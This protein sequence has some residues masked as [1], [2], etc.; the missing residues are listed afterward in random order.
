[1]S[2]RKGRSVVVSLTSRLTALGGILIREHLSRLGGEKRGKSAPSSPP[3]SPS[4]GRFCTPTMLPSCSPGILSEQS[5]EDTDIGRD[6]ARHHVTS[7]KWPPC[8]HCDMVPLYHCP[9]TLIVYS[10]DPF[11][12]PRGSLLNLSSSTSYLYAI[13]TLIYSRY[14]RALRVLLL[15]CPPSKNL[16]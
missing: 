14:L 15:A 1:M 10:H 7:R 3:L 11:H 2:T 5:A 4:P 9:T 6:Q 12:S 13:H 8:L 16:P